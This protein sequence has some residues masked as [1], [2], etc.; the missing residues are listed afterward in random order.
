MNL[1]GNAV[2]FTATGSVRVLCSV[3]A[4]PEESYNFSLKFEIACVQLFLNL[5]LFLTSI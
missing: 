4:V 3:D 1:I 5:Y 2:K